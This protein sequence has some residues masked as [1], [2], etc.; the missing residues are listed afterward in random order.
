MGVICGPGKNETHNQ[1]AHYVYDQRSKGEAAMVRKLG[2]E[3]GHSETKQRAE[4]G[5][6]REIQDVDRHQADSLCENW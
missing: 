5:A 6:Q 1:A 3:M 2:G 4:D